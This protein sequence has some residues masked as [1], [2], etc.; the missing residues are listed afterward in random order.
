MLM[1]ADHETE[2]VPA[3]RIEIPPVTQPIKPTPVIKTVPPVVKPTVSRELFENFQT[4]ES[5]TTGI[6]E[7]FNSSY[8]IRIGAIVVVC[9]IGLFVLM[10]FLSFN[11][12]TGNSNANKSS[13]PKSSGKF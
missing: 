11:D 2:T 10:I 12:S 9:L 1:Q 13:R 5:Y 6:A 3:F 4:D 7:V 8:Y